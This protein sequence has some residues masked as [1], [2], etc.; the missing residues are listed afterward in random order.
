[1]RFV[2]IIVVLLASAWL[3]CG[4]DSVREKFLNDVRTCCDKVIKSN[5]I[6]ISEE[7]SYY[8]ARANDEQVSDFYFL[9]FELEKEV[10]TL[11]INNSKRWYENVEINKLIIDT[12]RRLNEVELEIRTIYVEGDSLFLQVVLSDSKAILGT[13]KVKSV[14]ELRSLQNFQVGNISMLDSLKSMQR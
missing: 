10:H 3:G 11:M 6:A 14:Y 4:R 2:F 5:Q 8:L 7:G 1:M 9:G 13:A 12:E